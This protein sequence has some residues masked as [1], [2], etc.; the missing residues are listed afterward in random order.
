MNKTVLLLL[1]TAALCYS[2]S[3][4]DYF[5]VSVPELPDPPGWTVVE[6]AAG[7]TADLNDK[8]TNADSNTV[9]LVPDG[10]YLRRNMLSLPVTIWSKNERYNNG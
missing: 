10:A 1:A 7:D 5:N 6:V 3:V 4:S 8:I 9:I 2:L